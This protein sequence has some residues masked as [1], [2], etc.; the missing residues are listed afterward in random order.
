MEAS[1]HQ[2]RS[3]IDVHFEKRCFEKT[4]FFIWKNN[5]F[6]GS[7]AQSWDEKS[8]KNGSKNGIEYQSN[9]HC[10]LESIFI[11]FFRGF[12]VDKWRQVGTK[13][14]PKSMCT[15]KTDVL[16][17]PYFSLRKTTF[18]QNI[19]FRSAHRFW[20]DFGANFPLFF[21]QKSNKIE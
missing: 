6:E 13:I 1:W 7:G 5:T 17:K 16:K 3:K 20:I 9:F 14:D 8:I 18:F 12:L 11:Q 21:H 15:S 4:L 19:D 10:L 2:D